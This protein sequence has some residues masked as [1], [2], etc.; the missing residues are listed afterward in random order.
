MLKS[1]LIY[2]APIACGAML[3][4]MW[5]PMLLGRRGDRS[6]DV[7]DTRQEL[8]E[9]RAEIARLKAEPLGEGSEA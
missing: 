3:V 4:A 1:L 6:S 9:L 2:L 7:G 8:A 5:W